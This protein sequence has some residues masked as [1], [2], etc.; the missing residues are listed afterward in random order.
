MTQYILFFYFLF[1]EEA[2]KEG[3]LKASNTVKLARERDLEAAFA[4][5]CDMCQ[6]QLFLLPGDK[7]R[8]HSL[9]KFHF[10]KTSAI[11]LSSTAVLYKKPD[12]YCK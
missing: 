5:S 7:G 12:V 10:S 3:S 1:Y 9:T 2:Q 11:A 4:A 6:Q 8:K